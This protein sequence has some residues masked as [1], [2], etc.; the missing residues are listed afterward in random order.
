MMGVCTVQGGPS[1]GFVVAQETKT[2]YFYQ[3][4]KLKEEMFLMLFFCAVSAK[5]RPY[6]PHFP[7]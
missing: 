1:Q 5:W 4:K 3:K 7:P 2:L 6:G